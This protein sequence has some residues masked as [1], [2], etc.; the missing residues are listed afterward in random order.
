MKTTTTAFADHLEEEVTTLCTCW[1]IE[2]TDGGVLGFTDH[3]EDLTFNGVFYDSVHGYTSTALST[4]S[5]LSVDNMDVTGILDSDLITNEDLK[6]GLF[7]F[8]SVYIFVLN[9]TDLSQGSMA[10]RRGWFGEVTVGQNGMFKT[11][12]RGLTQALSHNYVE[13]YTPECRTDF[14]DDRCSLSIKDYEREGTVLEVTGTYSKFKSS[15]L[16]APDVP[17]GVGAY[18]DWRI[19]LDAVLDPE[20]GGFAE[21]QFFDENGDQIRGGDT[22]CSTSDDGHGASKARDNKPS[23]E[24][25]TDTGFDDGEEGAVIVGAWWSISWGDPKNV[26]AVMMQATENYLESPT[27]FRLQYSPDGGTTWHT[28]KSCEFGWSEGGQKALWSLSSSSSLPINLPS[29]YTALPPPSV[30]A[31]TYVGGTVRFKAGRNSGKVM[32]IV[33]YDNTTDE[34]TLFTNLPYPI[35]VGDTF[36]IAQG[37]DKRFATCK[38]YN[39]VVNFRGEPYVPGQDEFLS[40]PD[41]H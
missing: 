1:R 23:S 2:R 33:A 41:S 30:G 39:N 31:S 22:D 38:V 35:E 5:D 6:N 11:E 19:L 16:P 21:I 20:H 7:D 18:K 29:T 40:Y 24:W 17:P 34:V 14:C 36:T 27:A 15:A 25:S 3:D 28:A 8:A 26:Q 12:L 32:E 4:N 9:W 37:C 10:L 13:V